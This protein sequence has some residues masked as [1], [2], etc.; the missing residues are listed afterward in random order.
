M[1][2]MPFHI[3]G[4]RHPS[5]SLVL[6]AIVFVGLCLAALLTNVIT[7]RSPLVP[8]TYP[9]LDILQNHYTGVPGAIRFASFLQVGAAIVLAV[10]TATAA[11][12]LRFLRVTAAGATIALVG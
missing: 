7:A 4:A 1:T 9:P 6:V 2:N 11:S 12:R 3:E 8:S 5:P 10:F